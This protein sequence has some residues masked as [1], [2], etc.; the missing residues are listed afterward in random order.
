ML[1]FESDGKYRRMIVDIDKSLVPQELIFW[2][3]TI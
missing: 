1:D 2:I 3:L